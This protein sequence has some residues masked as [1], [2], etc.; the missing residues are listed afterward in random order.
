MIIFHRI[1]NQ[2]S[3]Q[4][5]LLMSQDTQH[6]P[7]PRRFVKRPGQGLPQNTAIRQPLSL[8]N[9]RTGEQ[10]NLDKQRVSGISLWTVVFFK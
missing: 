7:E 5:P 4:I 6:K 3:Q 1:V 9:S 8:S 2:P 10:A